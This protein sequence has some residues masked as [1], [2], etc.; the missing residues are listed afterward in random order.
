MKKTGFGVAWIGLSG[1]RGL[2]HVT[3]ADTIPDFATMQAA[4][5]HMPSDLEQEGRLHSQYEGWTVLFD[6]QESLLSMQNGPASISGKLTFISGNSTWKVSRSRDGAGDRYALVDPRDNVQGYLVFLLNGYEIRLLF[7]HRTAQAFSGKWSLQ[8]EIRFTDDCFACRTRPEKGERV[9]SMRYGTADSLRNDSLFAPANDNVLQLDAPQLGIRYLTDGQ[10]AL[11]V[12]GTIEESSEATFSVR[13]EPQYFKRRYVPYYHPID[14]K[15]CPKTPT[16]WMSWNTYFDKATAED[17]LNEAKIGKKYLQPFGCDIWSIE[18]WQ[19]NSDQ[20]PVRDFFNMNLEV[21][22]KQFPKGMKKLADDIRSLGFR[23]GLWMAPFGTGSDDFYESHKHWFLHDK[24]GQPIISWNGKYTL[25]PTVTEAREHL[26]KIFRTASREWGYEF[27]KVDGMSG[28]NQGYCAHLYE[29]PEIRAVFKDPACPNPF[30]L[31]VQA[32]REGIGDDRLFLACQGHTSGP[33]A[34]YADASRIGADIVSPNKPVE[35]NG[36]MNQGRCF[37]NQAF[38]HNISMIADPDTL[39]VRDL[40]IE[41]AR[42]SATIV[43]LPGQ[44]TFFGDKLAGLSDDRMKILQQTL[45]VAEVYP[46]NLYPCFSM[47]PVWNLHIRHHLLGDYNVVALFNWEDKPQT[48][49]VTATELGIDSTIARYGY[50]FWTEQAVPFNENLSMEVPAHG[51]RLI[52]L[53]PALS[54]PQW[55]SSDCHIA[56]H[57]EELTEYEWDTERLCLRGKIRVVGGFPL[58]ARFHIPSNYSCTRVTC[59]GA[60]AI[61][62][63]ESGI[64]SVTFKTD[65]STTVAFNINTTTV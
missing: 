47:L 36:V 63:E 42:T 35:W 58:T 13:L 28:R 26:K 9:L 27:F 22:Q 40:P 25:D 54:I 1:S 38:T 16:G 62:Q 57:A 24:N 6:E 14:R 15:R 3:A 65:K 20:L 64:L 45:P 34:L 41:E 59:E 56:Q 5:E 33:E 48:I 10:F 12:S 50:E 61:Q 44:L 17:N 23:P 21:N 49:Q 4:A 11:T 55:L 18:S 31:C 19:G 52:A 2:T 60:S 53:Y 8:G 29:R 46:G 7:Y 32:F 37:I 30:E 51:V 43:A 39:L